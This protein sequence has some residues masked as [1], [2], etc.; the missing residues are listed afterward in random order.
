MIQA[1]HS[2]FF[3]DP[4]LLLLQAVLRMRFTY[5]PQILYDV[6]CFNKPCLA[7]GSFWVFPVVECGYQD[8]VK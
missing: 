1:I 5:T 2:L 6:L 7:F 3:I 4:N 8:A